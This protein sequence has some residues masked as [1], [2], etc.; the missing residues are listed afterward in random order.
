MKLF[1]FSNIIPHIVLFIFG[2]HMTIGPGT[3]LL[4]HL[5]S[6]HILDEQFIPVGS[7]VGQQEKSN[8]IKFSPAELIKIPYIRNFFFTLSMPCFALCYFFITF[9]RKNQE[10]DPLLF[11]NSLF[12]I[13]Y[14]SI[15][16]SHKK[17]SIIFAA[18]SIIVTLF[19][20]QIENMESIDNRYII[21]IYIFVFIQ[22][23]SF[24]NS[25]CITTKSY[26][27]YSHPPIAIFDYEQCYSI[28][29]TLYSGFWHF[30]I[31][32][33]HHID[34]V[35]IIAYVVTKIDVLEIS[36]KNSSLLLICCS[37]FTCILSLP[38]A[39]CLLQLKI[40]VMM[41]PTFTKN[42]NGDKEDLHK[43]VN[44]IGKISF[45][46]TAL[47]SHLFILNIGWIYCNTFISENTQAFASI[48]QILIF[49]GTVL[50]CT[51]R[52]FS[53]VYSF[54]PISNKNIEY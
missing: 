36:E 37:M 4:H 3:L 10:P 28:L 54:F 7:I 27:E 22:F 52:L 47:P 38:C 49:T 11:V 13:I 43:L 33:W 24:S 50:S 45:S 44:P 51:A 14:T 53:L 26:Y 18:A 48:L 29:Q 19:A 31:T 42:K 46:L 41:I 15:K 40:I 8:M 21:L 2:W 12:P 30:L 32:V 1:S 16:L 23:F 6:F 9:F 20:L 39:K 34:A 5:K 25:I 35:V 17:K